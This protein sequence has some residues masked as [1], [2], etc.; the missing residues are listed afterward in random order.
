V[1]TRVRLFFSAQNCV[2]FTVSGD[3]IGSQWS[4]QRGG[5][6]R[7]ALDWDIQ[8]GENQSP[9]SESIVD[10]SKYRRET[11]EASG[12]KNA[13]AENRKLEATVNLGIQAVKE[14]R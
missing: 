12:V 10:C 5:F 9:A 13:S 11:A 8:R 1:I 14:D 6:F 3:G 7:P 4:E 2:E